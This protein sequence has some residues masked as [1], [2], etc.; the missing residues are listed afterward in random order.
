M[1][2]YLSFLCGSNLHLQSVRPARR[3]QFYDVFSKRSTVTQTTWHI[4]RR[5]LRERVAT[6][7]KDR[8]ENFCLGGV[9]SWRFGISQKAYEWPSPHTQ[10]PPI[11][12]CYWFFW[13]HVRKM[14]TGRRMLLFSF[15]RS[16]T[17]PVPVESCGQISTSTIFLILYIHTGV[18]IRAC[19]TCNTKKT[20]KYD[21]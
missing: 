1:S 12:N 14:C 4:F 11:H 7:P 19:C 6:N 10:V 20:P 3:I 13:F 2:T 17:Y 5:V 9:W 18:G 21:P 16:Q 15:W 8:A